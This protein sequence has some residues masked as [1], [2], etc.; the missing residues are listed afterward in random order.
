MSFKDL[1]K[2]KNL[3]NSHVQKE[4]EQ[5]FV[6]KTTKYEKIPLLILFF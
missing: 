1:K 6:V 3:K 5:I 4:G 2:K